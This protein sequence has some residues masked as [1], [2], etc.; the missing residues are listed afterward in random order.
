MDIVDHVDVSPQVLANFFD[1]IKGT[2]FEELSL[3]VNCPSNDVFEALISSPLAHTLRRLHIEHSPIL[4][5]FSSIPSPER[6]GV[7]NSPFR[8]PDLRNLQELIITFPSVSKVITE[9]AEYTL[10]C[11]KEKASQLRRLW[12]GCPGTSDWGSFRRAAARPILIFTKSTEQD[13]WVTEQ[14]MSASDRMS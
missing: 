8:A 5:F 11:L 12:F 6:L 13:R 7:T 10:E 3:T 14:V 1:E 2:T 9:K 4:Q